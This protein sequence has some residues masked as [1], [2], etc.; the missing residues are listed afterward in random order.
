MGLDVQLVCSLIYF[1]ITS[2]LVFLFCFVSNCHI[3][4]LCYFLTL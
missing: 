3:I 4:F 2:C 1:T